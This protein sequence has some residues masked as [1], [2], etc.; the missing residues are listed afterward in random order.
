MISVPCLKNLKIFVTPR[1]GRPAEKLLLEQAL[2]TPEQSSTSFSFFGG[3]S[4]EDETSGCS[5][6]DKSS[7]YQPGEERTETSEEKVRKLMKSANCFVF[8]LQCIQ[9]ENVQYFNRRWALKA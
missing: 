8:V 3:S 2:N 7:S 1:A 4:L 5:K 9:R 6:S